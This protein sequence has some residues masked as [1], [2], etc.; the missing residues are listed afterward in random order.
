M[1]NAIDSAVT[2]MLNRSRE[3]DITSNNLA[4]LNTPGFRSDRL[5]TT[6]F[7][8]HLTYRLNAGTNEEIGSQNY[9]SI[10][11][12]VYTQSTQGA[13]EFT[14]RKLDFTI[15]GGGYFTL[16]RQ[17]GTAAYTRNGRFSI[18]NGGFLINSSG[19][20]VMGQNGRIFA[21]TAEITVSSQGDIYAGG[22]Y[23]DRLSLVGSDGTE[24]LDKLSQS[25]LAGNLNQPF[26]GSIVQGALEQS[27][28][29]MMTEMSIMI[30]SSRAF[31][32]CSQFVKML[33][34]LMQK[35]VTEIGRV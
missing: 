21:G 30:E 9:G 1:M 6:D 19:A 15:N 14:N 23:I 20:Y 22:D 12:N 17:D 25:S 11:D 35:T 7:K 16:Q 32:T 29:D 28:V 2:G 34:Q 8:D 4:N 18:D 3:L 10:M 5:I 27:G 26:T 24:R 33:D 13:P 31:Q